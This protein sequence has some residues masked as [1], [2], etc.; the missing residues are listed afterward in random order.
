MIR[1]FQQQSLSISQQKGDGGTN[2]MQPAGVQGTHVLFMVIRSQL[3]FFNHT[4]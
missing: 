3:H 1:G 2:D 4:Y